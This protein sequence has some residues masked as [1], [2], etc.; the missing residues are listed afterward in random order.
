MQKVFDTQNFVVRKTFFEFYVQDGGVFNYEDL[1][2][3]ISKSDLP[4]KFQNCLLIGFTN[5]S[6]E[7]K[8][9]CDISDYS[10][11]II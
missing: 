5:L 6:P 2:E 8:Q 9:K 3:M 7:L 1:F 11:R 4:I 10:N